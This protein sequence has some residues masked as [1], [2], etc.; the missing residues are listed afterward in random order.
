[1][2][3][4]NNYAMTLLASDIVQVIRSLDCGKVVLMGHD[5]GGGVCWDVAHGHPEL[6]S[7]LVIACAAH[8]RTFRANMDFTQF[9]RSWYMFL[10]QMPMIP[11][12]GLSA[13]DFKSLDAAF[14]KPPMG[15]RRPG[16]LSDV[17]M[18][19]YKKEM[20]RP[21]TL[22][23]AINYYRAMARTMAFGPDRRRA[24]ET[25]S[26]RRVLDVP[27]LV[28]WADQ[29]I[30]LGPGLLRGLGKYVSTLRIETLKDCSHWAQQ[31]RP[32]EFNALVAAFLKE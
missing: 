20:A 14:R 15:V 30:A 3:G 31:D 6:L 1:M 18:S 22:T 13:E 12:L 5:W 2:Q 16:A 17:E 29:D 28:I 4:I 24:K 11:E 26:L 27:T 25:Q 19:A 10:F 7:N 9:L 21:G 23:S 32:E 8:P